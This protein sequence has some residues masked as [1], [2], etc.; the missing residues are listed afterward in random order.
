M[1]YNNFEKSA[2][3]MGFSYLWKAFLTFRSASQNWFIIFSWYI[4]QLHNNILRFWHTATSRSLKKQELFNKSDWKT[5][6]WTNKQT[7]QT[8]LIK[9]IHSCEGGSGTWAKESAAAAVALVFC[10]LLKNFALQCQIPCDFNIYKHISEH[11]ASSFCIFKVSKHPW[12]ILTF[13]LVWWT[14]YFL[15]LRCFRSVGSSG[16]WELY[17]S[18]ATI[19][20][21][22]FCLIHS[23]SIHWMLNTGWIQE[24]RLVWFL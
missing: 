6:K 10:D 16:C 11:L 8:F 21:S 24:T 7:K 3:V 4:F 14:Y 9:A 1:I 12:A 22:E 15:P 20:L 13:Q 5:K 2:F 19:V 23:L 17:L 18:C